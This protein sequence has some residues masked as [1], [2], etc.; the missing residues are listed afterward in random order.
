MDKCVLFFRISLALLSCTFS[1][2]CPFTSK[3][4]RRKKEEINPV[5]L[6]KQ[7]EYNRLLWNYNDTKSTKATSSWITARHIG[8][9]RNVLSTNVN[10]PGDDLWTTSFIQRTK[11]NTSGMT[12]SPTHVLRHSSEPCVLQIVFTACPLNRPD[13]CILTQYANQPSFVVEVEV[14]FDRNIRRDHPLPPWRR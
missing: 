13:I 1:K 5:H 14:S 2:F 4:C 10:V 11:R 3:I 8:S 7:A 9:G 6:S 12:F